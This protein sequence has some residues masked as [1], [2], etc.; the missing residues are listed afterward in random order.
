MQ[1]DAGGEPANGSVGPS[2]VTLGSLRREAL[3][4]RL[5]IVARDEHGIKGETGERVARFF[6]RASEFYR[7]NPEGSR[8]LAVMGYDSKEQMVLLDIAS[9]LNPPLNLRYIP[10]S[11]SPSNGHAK[12]DGKRQE[13]TRQP[14]SVEARAMTPTGSGALSAEPLL[15]PRTKPIDSTDRY[16]PNATPM[17]ATP[18]EPDPGYS[19]IDHFETLDAPWT[20]IDHANANAVPTKPE[21]PYAG[22]TQDQLLAAYREKKAQVAER[23]SQELIARRKMATEPP[24]PSV[25]LPGPSYPPRGPLA[26][27]G[28]AS[29]AQA[30]ETTASSRNGAEGRRWQSPPVLPS[31]RTDAIP[32]RVF[33][34]ILAFLAGA[35]PTGILGFLEATRMVIAPVHFLT[36]LVL[37]AA[38]LGCIGAAIITTVVA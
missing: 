12:E 2:W 33:G 13:A 25:Q 34:V 32:D 27:P 3:S 9:R 17:P 36:P 24:A 29:P 5:A 4:S 14:V 38:A 26:T 30:D 15:F 16:V 18:T 20:L 35:V 37:F 8:T 31:Q 1:G 28:L 21:N 6:D 22:M 19:M 23:V 11:L 7:N 10:T